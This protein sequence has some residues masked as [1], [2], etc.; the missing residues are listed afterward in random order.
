MPKSRNWSN[1]SAPC[2]L[3]WRPSRLLAAGL[4]ALGM[5]AAASVLGSEIPGPAA[6]PSA[7]AAFGYGLRLARREL[8]R[9]V[10]GLIIPPGDGAAML[11]GVP[12][13]DFDVQWRGPLAFLQWRDAQGLRQRIQYWPDTLPARARR[14][15]RLAMVARA[16]APN[17][18][19]MAP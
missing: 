6:W 13:T 17:A 3:E 4:L 16:S 8:R 19:S 1:I 15:L 9:P 14:E 10:R 11:D 5:L 7:L 12:M 18:R 2:R